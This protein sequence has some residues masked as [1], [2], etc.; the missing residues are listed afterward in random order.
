MNDLYDLVPFPNKIR[1]LF[2]LESPYTDEIKVGFPVAGKAGKTMARV[3]LGNDTIPFG[4]YLF[5]RNELVSEYGIFNSCQ[6]PLEIT[7][8]LQ[9][10]ELKI[11]EIKKVPQKEDDRDYNYRELSKFLKTIENLDL[12]IRYKERFKQLIEN[13]PSIETFVFCGFIAQAIFLELYPNVP[14]PPYN[15]PTQLN[16]KKIHFVNHPSEKGSKWVYKICS[17]K[18]EP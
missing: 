3:I 18:I 8:N 10:S 17:K 6:F 5:N 2:I 15:K 14:I 7:E 1:T 13:S 4:D 11:S 16:S 9:E 12:E